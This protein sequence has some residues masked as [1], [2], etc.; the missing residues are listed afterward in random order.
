MTA[1]EPRWLRQIDATMSE[2]C[3]HG[4]FPGAVLHLRRG[5]ELV[6]EQAY[7]WRALWPEPVGNTAET[8]Y[9]IASLTKPLATATICLRFFASGRLRPDSAI[10]EILPEFD[11]PDKRA[12][13]VEQLLCHSSG[14]P[15]WKP[16][17]ETLS[18]PALSN[19]SDS[20]A[21]RWARLLA[22]IAA[23]PL[24]DEPG[25]TTRYSDLGYM[26]LAALLMRRGAARFDQLF[27]REVAEPLGLD[28]LFF[29][30]SDIPR[31]E[32]MALA[33]TEWD[34]QIQNW[35]F[36]QVHDENTDFLGGVS[37]QAGLFGTAAAVGRWAKIM[38]DC[39]AGRHPFLEPKWVDYFF[40]PKVTGNGRRTPG[41]DTPEPVGSSAGDYFSADAVGHLGFTGTSLWI[42]P[43]SRIIV[44]LLS[45]RV[46]PSRKND[47]IKAFR[48]RIHNLIMAGLGLGHNFA[49]R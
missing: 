49:Q 10:G 9:D 8:Y 39:R 3:T 48:P 35:K 26:I 42:E 17:F 21:E 29:R 20:I 34:N 46:H 44:V 14:F 47:K 1:L 6:Y 16:Y 23:E 30:P 36:G 24:M 31:P 11:L 7:G 19:S 12:I 37:G 25:R 43:Q 13:T 41:L 45:N 5:E 32:D 28:Q 27:H 4:V 2:A 15:A 22:A 18:T 33:P 40:T 38:L